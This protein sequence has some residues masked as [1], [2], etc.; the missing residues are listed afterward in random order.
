MQARFGG[1]N[2]AGE[3]G[4]NIVA[5]VARQRRCGKIFREIIVERYSR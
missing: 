1:L 4:P 2:A 5:F 3:F